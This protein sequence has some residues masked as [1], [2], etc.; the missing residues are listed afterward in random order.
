MSA[1]VIAIDKSK[2]E[3]NRTPI[4]LSNLASQS[5]AVRSINLQSTGGHR[6]T[7]QS[8]IVGSGR[9]TLAQMGD[10]L[11]MSQSITSGFGQNKKGNK[12]AP[13][14]HNKYQSS[15]VMPDIKVV[16]LSTKR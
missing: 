11:M 14:Q 4:Q 5:I 7:R 6:P 2:D 1:K 15:L 8:I 10:N 16:P 13:L 9:K 3:M 12:L